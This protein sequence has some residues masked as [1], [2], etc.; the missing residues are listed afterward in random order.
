MKENDTCQ[1]TGT[2]I[3]KCKYNKNYGQD[4]LS[5]TAEKCKEPAY[6]LWFHNGNSMG[7]CYTEKDAKSYCSNPKYCKEKNCDPTY[8]D[9][10]THYGRKIKAFVGCHKQEVPDVQ[11]QPGI[12]EQPNYVP[13]QPTQPI[14]HL[15]PAETPQGE[16]EIA[17]IN[18]PV[19]S[20]PT[21]DTPN[22][23]VGAPVCTTEK[24]C[25]P[26]DPD[27]IF[28]TIDS[29]LAYYFAEGSSSVWKNDEGKFNTARLV[30]DSVAGVVLGTVGGV[31]TSQVIKKNQIKNGFQ[32]L[33]CTI[34]GQTV[35]TY[36]DEFRV[37]VK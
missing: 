33:K 28:Q 35:A 25:K 18:V 22:I 20:I 10:K 37:G 3:A 5:C 34:G 6:R 32:D 16:P 2:E 29:D 30:S 21:D 26:V 24:G 4:V 31:V 27:A 9:N 36:G 13:T 11:P 23:I 17:E 14:Q 8:E 19:P 7:T 1:K 15:P 12:P